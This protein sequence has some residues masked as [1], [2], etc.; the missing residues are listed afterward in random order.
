MLN[1]RVASVL[2]GSLGLIIA[3]CGIKGSQLGDESDDGGGA[4]N[5]VG[6]S[7]GSFNPGAGGG[8]TTIEDPP[9][10]NDPGIDGDGDG[11]TGAQNDCNDC[12]PQ[13]NPGAYDYAGNNVDE[14]CN[15]ASDDTVETCDGSLPIESMD[16]MEAVRAMEL[17][18]LQSGEA[19]GVI[20]AS[21]I[22]VDGAPAAGG[23]FDLGHGVL[24]AFGASVVPQGGS[25]MFAVSSGA[26]RQPNDPGFQHPGGFDKTYTSNAAPG[27]PKESP[28]CPGIITGEA[29]D[30][31]ALRLEIKTPTNAK[32]FAFNVNFYTWEYPGFICSTYNDFVTAIMAPAPSGL[33]DADCQGTP[34]GN[35][36]FDLMGNPLSVNAGF[37][38]VCSPGTYGGKTFDCSLG[39]SQLM[40]TG[41]EDHAATGWLQTSAPVEDPG[42]QIRLELGA[43][44]SGDGILDTTGLF[45]N[46]VW[47]LEDTPTQTEPVPNPK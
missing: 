42:S 11:F 47:S 13:I 3:A 32:S 31:I 29:H 10:D 20:S 23:N 26:A 17:C 8:V 36:S 28:A 41:F 5:S 27:F 34:C 16:A 22:N 37:L 7:T 24:S 2:A 12:T 30:S 9:C 35:I 25:Q 40:G 38:E 43:W 19:W 44:D 46:F 21:Y 4:G 14:D 15:G 45:D 1:I 39:T 6:G 18:T 33:A